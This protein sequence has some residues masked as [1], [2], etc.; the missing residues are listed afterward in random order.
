[1]ILTIPILRDMALHKDPAGAKP[2]S[3]V[4]QTT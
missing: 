1:L 3:R 2:A 4:K